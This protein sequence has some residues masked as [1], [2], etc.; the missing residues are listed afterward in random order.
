MS[1][2]KP[3]TQAELDE[4]EFRE[5]DT[6]IKEVCTMLSKRH[7]RKGTRQRFRDAEVRHSMSTHE[8]SAVAT[9]DALRF[10]TT[11]KMRHRLE[12][13]DHLKTLKK[14]LE[15]R[16]DLQAELDK[17]TERQLTLLMRL[18]KTEPCDAPVL[19]PS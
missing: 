17:L 2:A 13:V 9:V 15:Y 12:M 11:S 5:L 18:T 1:T 14:L 16:A 7:D 8:E 3:K 19:N 6:K 10:A 4:E